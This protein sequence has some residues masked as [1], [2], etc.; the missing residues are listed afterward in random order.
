MSD[1]LVRSEFV[2]VEMRSTE[3]GGS[4]L[5]KGALNGVFFWTFDEEE[6]CTE[7]LWGGELVPELIGELVV[8]VAIMLVAR[9]CAVTGME[10]R[11]AV[12]PF[13]TH[14]TALSH[15]PAIR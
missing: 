10:I 12:H 3:G 7:G 8:R 11:W 6:V 5:H 13:V 15:F 4:V 1:S 2:K 9:A 14:C